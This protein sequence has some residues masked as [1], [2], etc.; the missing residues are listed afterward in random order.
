MKYQTLVAFAIIAATMCVEA[1]AQKYVPDRLIVRFQEG[2]LDRGTL[3][4]GERS[5]DRQSL[6]ADRKMSNFL[7]RKGV[8]RLNRMFKDVRPSNRIRVNRRGR[9]VTLP[10]LH[11]IMVLDLPRGSDLRFVMDS[12]SALPGVVYV[13]RA[14][15]Q[16]MPSRE[17]RSI[18]EQG[19]SKATFMPDDPLFASQKSLND[20]RPQR[21]RIS[22]CLM[23]RHLLEKATGAVLRRQL[24]VSCRKI[25]PIR[26]TRRP[27]SNTPCQKQV[28]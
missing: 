22:R 18:V 6:V 1:R 17:N 7:K 14:A 13:H 28:M 26:L 5:L 16:E 24:R 11:N 27:L 21:S 10:P 23:A 9:S 2:V 25:D 20:T 8:D 3:N 12:L 4:G 15:I 19:L